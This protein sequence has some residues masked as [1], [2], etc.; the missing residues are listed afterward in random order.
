MR[1]ATPA[2]VLLRQLTRIV[3]RYRPGS[4]ATFLTCFPEV[5]LYLTGPTDCQGRQLPFA[6]CGVRGMIAA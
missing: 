3:R 6:M 2:T 1:L 5:M 4:I